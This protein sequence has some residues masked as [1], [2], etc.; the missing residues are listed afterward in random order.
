MRLSSEVKKIWHGLKRVMGLYH[1]R[2]KD[3]SSED[4][5]EN[6]YKA[7]GNSGAGSYNRLAEFKAE[8]INA[9]VKDNGVDTV[10][11]LG[12]GDG[13]QLSLLKVNHY[14][15]FDVSETA[16]N[17]CRSKF[18]NDSTKIFKKYS[19]FHHEKADLALSLDV[20]YHLIENH[21]FESY[22]ENLFGASSK[23]VI[24]Y[25]SNK[26]QEWCEHVKHRKF[27]DWIGKNK[28]EWTLQQF[29]PNR[30]PFDENDQNNTS[31][32]DFYIYKKTD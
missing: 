29:I 24:I 5:W 13:N 11:E 23:Y 27:T 15:G 32:A 10:L 14:I 26:E 1:I 17:L 4:Y 2:S 7:H 12:C 25:A 20:I 31:F 9:F 18:K 19:E 22:M 3:F 6:R 16:L 21:V 30:Y 8:I 28:R